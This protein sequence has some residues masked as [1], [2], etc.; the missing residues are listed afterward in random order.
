M[1]ERQGN[2]ER[3]RFFRIDDTLGV[4][5][6]LLSEAELSEQ[7]RAEQ[8]PADI[9]ALLARLDTQL[10]HSLA[11]LR[12][13]QPPVAEV[14]DT[15]NKKLNTVIHQLEADNHLVR[16]LAQKVQEVNIS[17]CGMAFVCDEQIEAGR[18]LGLELALKPSNLHIH[19]RARV[20]ACE[21][22]DDGAGYYLRLDFSDISDT[23][24]EVLIQ[25]IV[26]RQSSIIRKDRE[27]LP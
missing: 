5:Y 4:A 21:P 24:Q 17:A 18:V 27:S 19:T 11:T 14:L 22:V 26:K 9:F 15:L 2:E 1:T 23:D 3:R 8:A 6:R 16:R 25:H 7:P 13:K 20:V 10:E 12:V